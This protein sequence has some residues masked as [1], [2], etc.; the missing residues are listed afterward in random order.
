MFRLL[1]EHSACWEE[2]NLE[3]ISELLPLLAALRNRVPSLKRLWL[4][5]EDLE[6][7]T[8]AQSIDYFQSAPSLVDFGNQYFT[9]FLLPFQQLTR[10]QLD[11][12]LHRHLTILKL[13]PNLIEARLEINLEG[14]V[15]DEIRLYV[16]HGT[17][18]CFL[19]APALTEIALA[20]VIEDDIDDELGFLESF[21]DRSACPLRRLSLSG[22]PAHTT[23][24][25]LE[26]FPF[27]SELVI[28]VEDSYGQKEDV[29]DLIWILTLVTGKSLIAP[30]LCS[31]FFG[32][33]GD[34]CINHELYLEMLKSRWE[35]KSALQNAALVTVSCGPEPATLCGL[36]SL[37]REG[38]NIFLV[39]G[40]E[41]SLEICR[42]FYA[43]TWV[44]D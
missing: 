11:G 37:R 32:C 16:S 3:F 26:K 10:C 6:S 24:K 14:P 29:N 17:A 9:P 42:W 43:T 36:H 34:S 13:T 8:A 39:N 22:F 27:I 19:R 15:S 41:A 18:L 35:A 5:G 21:V 31:L 7:L 20:V 40:V 33:E 28:A 23:I 25:M 38:L 12:P 4:S 44:L 30:Q 2:F 1:S